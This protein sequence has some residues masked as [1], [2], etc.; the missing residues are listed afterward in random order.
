MSQI[1]YETENEAQMKK[2]YNNRK[3][4]QSQRSKKS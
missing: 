1:P 3:N 2:N 4:C